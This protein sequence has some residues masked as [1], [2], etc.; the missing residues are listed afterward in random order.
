MVAHSI[1]PAELK[2]ACVRRN[3][4]TLCGPIDYTLER[5][6]FTIVMGPNGAGKTT[7]L[8]MVHGLERLSA[9]CVDW[10]ADEATVR[11]NQA[12]VFQSPIV[13]R[14]SVL[15]NVAYPLIIHGTGKQLARDKALNWLERIGL[16]EAAG[17]S[18]TVLSGGERQKVALARA[19]IRQP[20]LLFLDEPCS[21]LDG[22][23]TREIETLLTAAHDEGVRIVMA[24]H[25]VGQARRLSTDVVFIH[26]GRLHEYGPATPFFEN[27]QT[28]EA[29]AFLRGD[30]VE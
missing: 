10:Q 6:G 14:R 7:L 15:D 8:R 30:I 2:G 26:H 13:L 3:G 5:D 16:A 25:D 20:Q 28:R 4:H 24:T 21:N 29:R 22:R 27:A 1:L 9:G 19:L 23:A 18:A 12:F 11:R 17:R